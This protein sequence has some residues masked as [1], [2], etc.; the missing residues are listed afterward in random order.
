MRP[1]F[2]LHKWLVRYLTLMHRC[3]IPCMACNDKRFHIDDTQIFTGYVL[4]LN[5]QATE[6]HVK[7]AFHMVGDGETQPKPGVGRA[8]KRTIHG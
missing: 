5:R 3:Q 7:Q 8:W 1:D 2:V 4:A 6:F